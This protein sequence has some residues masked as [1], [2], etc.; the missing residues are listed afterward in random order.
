MMNSATI[1]SDVPS[2]SVGTRWRTTFWIV[3][4]FAL[5]ARIPFY[6]THHLQEDAYITF[7][8]AFNLADH[9]DYSFNLG[10]HTSGATSTLYGPLIAVVRLVFASHAIAAVS[11]LNTLIFLAGAAFLSFAFFEDWRERAIFLIFIAM[12]PEAMLITYTGMEIPLQAAVFCAIIFTLRR[13]RPTWA[14]LAGVFLLPLLRPDAIAY[15]L[16]LSALALT[17][18]RLRGVLAFIF[19]LLGSCAVLAFNRLTT[20]AFL[21]PTMRAKEVAYHPPHDLHALLGTIETLVFTRSYLLPVETKEIEWA[22]PLVTLVVLAACVAALYL[23]RRKPIVFRLLLACLAAGVFIPG[24]YMVGGVIFP[25]YF[26]TS[27]WLC[28]TLLCFVIVS[29]LFAI[30]PRMRAALVVLLALAWISLDGLQWLVSRNIG[31]QE[32]HYRA[33]VGRWLHQV[34]QPTDTLLLEPA[35]YI[36]FFSGLRTY[37]EIGLV[38][39]LVITYRSQYGPRWYMEFLRQ[40]HPTWIV[41]RDYFYDHIT[42]DEYHLTPEEILWF[43]AHYQL[44]RHFHYSPAGYLHPGLLLRLMKNGTHADYYVY[45]YTGLP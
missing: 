26:W 19:S 23:V 9:G 27:N 6:A 34:A 42:M 11:V 41:E 28:Y 24:A 3:F 44:V 32:Y 31:L 21:T 40:K 38:S 4:F 18:D 25:W 17:F 29:A 5:L 43:N 15:S 10:D 45:H 36:P 22:S 35:G 20:G 7:R 12:L 8:S 13:G 2:T 33:D 30:G 39:P 1:Q 14:T 37:D 16:I